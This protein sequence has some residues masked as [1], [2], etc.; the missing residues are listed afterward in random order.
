MVKMTCEREEWSFMSVAAK[1]PVCM[2]IRLL[3]EEGRWRRGRREEEKEE[4]EGGR[5]RDGEEGEERERERR[6]YTITYWWYYPNT[7][8]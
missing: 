5:R 2:C 4:G 3:G 1:A 6:T 7:I 8:I